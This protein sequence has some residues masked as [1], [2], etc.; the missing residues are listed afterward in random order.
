MMLNMKIPEGKHMDKPPRKAN[1]QLPT[2]TMDLLC[3]DLRL[4]NS[5]KTAAT[6][7]S[8]MPTMEDMASRHN[9]RKNRK[10]NSGGTGI[11]VMASGYTWNVRPTP[12]VI[13]DSTGT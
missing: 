1:T 3:P 8:H 12:A 6:V 4:G 2:Y 13:T 5:S 7:G 11:N 9:M 10:L